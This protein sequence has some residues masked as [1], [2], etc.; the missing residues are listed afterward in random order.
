MLPVLSRANI[1]LKAIVNTHHHHDHS[2]GNE[3]LLK[4]YPNLPIIAGA[5][6]PL[7]TFTPKHMEKITLGENLQITALHTPCH[8]QDSIC[9]FVHDTKTESNLVISGDTLFNAGCGR[10]FE[11][12]GA[13]MN[14]ALNLILARLPINTVV[15]P[16]HEYTRSNVRFNLKVMPENKLLQKLSSFVTLNE[17]TTGKFTIG[18]EKLYNPFMRLNDPS[19]IAFTG[20]SDPHDVMN[21]LREAKNNS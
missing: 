8:T 13:Q 5:D 16:G 10:F 21:A 9:Y 7:V 12:D 17:V 3:L 14:S 11:G 18:D 1:N 6:S 19:V 2:G 15:Y 20:K 4:A